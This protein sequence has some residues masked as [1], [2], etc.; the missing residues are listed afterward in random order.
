MQYLIYSRTMSMRSP[1][2]IGAC[3]ADAGIKFRHSNQLLLDLTDYTNTLAITR[4]GRWDW[5]G[6]PKSAVS[7]IKSKAR[8]IYVYLIECGRISRYE[9]LTAVRKLAPA[10]SPWAS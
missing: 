1:Q 8:Y 6:S 3:E 4:L 2:K 10:C 5:L 7:F 9:I